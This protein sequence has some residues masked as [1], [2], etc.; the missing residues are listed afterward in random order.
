MPACDEDEREALLGSHV[1]F[2]AIKSNWFDSLNHP[3]DTCDSRACWESL[4]DRGISREPRFIRRMKALPAE[5][6]LVQWNETTASL[7]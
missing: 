4:H 1:F 2:I 5:I 3:G 6:I 7:K